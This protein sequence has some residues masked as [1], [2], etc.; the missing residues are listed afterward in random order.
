MH[1]LSLVNADVSISDFV[2]QNQIGVFEG[3][4]IGFQELF[5]HYLIVGD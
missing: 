2:V 4:M 5:T 1:V 3:V